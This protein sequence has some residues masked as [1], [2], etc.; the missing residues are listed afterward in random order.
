[1]LN[2]FRIFLRS[3][4]TTQINFTLHSLPLL[5][6]GKVRDNYAVGEDKLLIVTS[7]RLSAFDVIMNEP[8]QT[9]AVY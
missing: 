7:D 5:G 6:R 4:M 8:I 3:I 1:M 2:L 9:K